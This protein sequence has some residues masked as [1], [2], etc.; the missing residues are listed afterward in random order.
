MLP[1]LICKSNR[2]VLVTLKQNKK[3][4]TKNIQ[5]KYLTILGPLPL[6]RH[7][8]A[9]SVGSEPV[10]P[11]TG[12]AVAK[13]WVLSTSHSTFR[14]RLQEGKCDSFFL[15]PF[16]PFLFHSAGACDSTWNKYSHHIR[17]DWC[18]SII[19]RLWLAHHYH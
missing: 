19:G 4:K 1:G 5:R 13:Y 7:A 15:F 10:P 2:A 6:I 9:I 18:N 14:F 17:R 12:P 16:L 3:Q 11:I 8:R